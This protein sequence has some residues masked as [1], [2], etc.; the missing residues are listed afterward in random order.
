MSVKPT[1]AITLGDPLGIGSEVVEKALNNSKLSQKAH[2]K[3]FGK[4]SSKMSAKKAGEVSWQALEDAVTALRSGEC[5]ALVTAPVSKT[6]LQLAGFPHPGQTEFLAHAFQTSRYAMMLA[7]PKLRVVLSTIHVPLRK[8]FKLLTPELIQEK[9]QITHESLKRDFGISKPR[10]GICGINPHAGENGLMGDDEEKI[11][12]PAIRL[13]RRKKIIVSDPLPP[14]TIFYQALQGKY[15]AV[16]CHYHDQGLIPLKTLFFDEGVNTTLGLP[17][18]RTSP[19]HGCAFDIAGKNLANPKSMR[20]AM[21]LAIQM[22]RNRR[23]SPLLLCPRR[24]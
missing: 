22:L 8:I 24:G 16:L 21:E 5:Q 11:L 1:L 9:I 3:I 14:D 4:S 13:V 19:D 15:D 7:A 20:A 6:H 10:I 12:M 17:I 18:I 2:W 23:Y